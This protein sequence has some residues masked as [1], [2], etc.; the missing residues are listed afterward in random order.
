MYLGEEVTQAVIA[1]PANFGFYQRQ[2]TKEAARIAGLETLFAR[3]YNGFMSDEELAV[4][5]NYHQRRQDCPAE[6]IWN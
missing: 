6:R 2:F 4:F 5:A 3:F 1:V